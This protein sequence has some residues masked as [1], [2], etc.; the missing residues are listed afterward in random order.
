MLL[1]ELAHEVAR[2]GE[3]LLE[4]NAVVLALVLTIK[5]RLNGIVQRVQ[6]AG[7]D[8]GLEPRRPQAVMEG[9]VSSRL[10]EHFN[11]LWRR[12]DGG[13]RVV[14]IV[15]VRGRRRVRR[16]GVNGA[17]A[18]ARVRVRRAGARARGGAR[19]RA[20]RLR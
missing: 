10:R 8:D 1:L 19:S 5:P 15:V 3:L 20:A 11:R 9:L 4:D 2:V 12:V 14:V 17:S 18:R 6:A 16:R 13:G 7:D